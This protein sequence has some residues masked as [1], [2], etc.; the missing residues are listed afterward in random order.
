[1]GY[2][3]NIRNISNSDWVNILKDQYIEHDYTTTGIGTSATNNIELALKELHDN[4]IS[5]TIDSYR[6][7]ETISTAASS[8]T[9]THNL[10]EKLVSVTIMDASDDTIISPSQVTFDST[11]QLTVTFNTAVSGDILII[12]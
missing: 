8:W 2:K 12:K 11:T 4:Y 6:Y 1:M 3:L 10:S 5:D 7:R 9:I